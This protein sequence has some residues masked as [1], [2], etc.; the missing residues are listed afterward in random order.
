M[1]WNFLSAEEKN[2]LEPP[3]PSPT[4]TPI[5]VNGNT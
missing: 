3:A 4:Q 1:F 2:R 5:K